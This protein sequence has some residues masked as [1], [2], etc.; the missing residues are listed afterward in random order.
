[1]LGVSTGWGGRE[2]DVCSVVVLE[3]LLTV[4]FIAISDT[5]M[6]SCFA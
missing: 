1:M 3:L 2:F 5:L 4:I 6:C